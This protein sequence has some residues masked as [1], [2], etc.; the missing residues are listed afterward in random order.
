MKLLLTH[1]EFEDLNN[2]E[3]RILLLLSNTIQEYQS[4]EDYSK[5]YEWRKV[6]IQDMFF[7]EETLEHG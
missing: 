3:D 2:M 7:D 4:E 5:L 6:L 1:F